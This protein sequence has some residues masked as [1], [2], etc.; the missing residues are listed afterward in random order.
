MQNLLFRFSS[1]FFL[2]ENVQASRKFLSKNVRIGQKFLSDFFFLRLWLGRPIRPAR[3]GRKGV[4]GFL[5][6][7]FALLTKG[8]QQREM[9]AVWR[10]RTWSAL[11]MHGC[12]AVGCGALRAEPQRRTSCRPTVVRR[13]LCEDGDRG[14]VL[15]QRRPCGHD[16]HAA[17]A[18]RS[19]WCS[20]RRFNTG[21]AE[22]QHERFR[23]ARWC[24]MAVRRLSDTRGCA[25][26]ES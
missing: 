24:A 19:V 8:Q 18:R 26:G 2:F 7:P 15:R 9:R 12:A 21:G 5:G 14:G 22:A 10:T 23:A 16:A 4:R 11:S 20:E 6:F 1:S 13:R 3:L 25:V 17:G